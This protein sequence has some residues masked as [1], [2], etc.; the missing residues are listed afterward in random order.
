[1]RKRTETKAEKTETFFFIRPSFVMMLSLFL[2]K[3]VV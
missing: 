3:M 1:M 2:P